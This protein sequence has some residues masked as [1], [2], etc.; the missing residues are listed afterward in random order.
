MA[1]ENLYD[2]VALKEDILNLCWECCN[3]T[4]FWFKSTTREIYKLTLKGDHYKHIN[5]YCFFNGDKDSIRNYYNIHRKTILKDKIDQM[6]TPFIHK[7]IACFEKR[8][9]NCGEMSLMVA[10]LIDITL[11]KRLIAKHHDEHLINAFFIETYILTPMKSTGDHAA[12]MIVIDNENYIIDPWA[13]E[14]FAEN[15]ATLFYN[16]INFPAYLAENMVLEINVSFTK[17]IKNKHNIDL[18][19]RTVLVSTGVDLR[20][21]GLENPFLTIKKF[22]AS[23]LLAKKNTSLHEHYADSNRIFS[24]K[25]LQTLSRQNIPLADEKRLINDIEAACRE[26]VDFSHKIIPHSFN[27]RICDVAAKKQEPST[28]ETFNT[29]LKTLENQERSADPVAKI[30]DRYLGF[31]SGGELGKG[32]TIKQIG[33]IIYNSLLTGCGEP[34]EMMRLTSLLATLYIGKRLLSLGYSQQ[35]IESLKVKI[36]PLVSY[37]EHYEY[38]LTRFDFVIN[39]NKIIYILDSFYNITFEFKELSKVYHQFG[40]PYF[41][42][43]RETDYIFDFDMIDVYKSPKQLALI[44]LIIKHIFAVDL[45]DYSVD[46]PFQNVTLSALDRRADELL[47]DL[48]PRKIPDFITYKEKTMELTERYRIIYYTQVLVHQSIQLKRNFISSGLNAISP[49]LSKRL[50]C[51]K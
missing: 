21:I 11:K 9:G 10:L 44:A 51:L 31:V 37:K 48:M 13:N 49:F 3:F 35:I 25:H 43:I 32:L 42:P 12:V 34:L 30:V 28:P 6:N 47:S 22:Q 33:H 26:C 7:L 46:N 18:F 29:L 40:Q 4:S 19:A 14:I 2:K 38:A 1:G 27:R 24:L 20:R 36:Y 23:L 8:V 39:N 45:L 50:N 17:F 15:D 5:S 41:I 16:K